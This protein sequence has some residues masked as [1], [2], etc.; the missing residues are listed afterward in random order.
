[1]SWLG[2]P[3][4]LLLSWIRGPEV[5]IIVLVL[6]LMFGATRLPKIGASLGQSLRAFKNS[7]SGQDQ[8]DAE[9]PEGKKVESKAGDEER[10]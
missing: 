1:M 2:E 7:V 5:V 6:L 10:S 8:G 9:E 4:L 3:P